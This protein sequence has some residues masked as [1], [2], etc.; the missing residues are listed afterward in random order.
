MQQIGADQGVVEIENQRQEV[1]T[2]LSGTGLFD[3]NG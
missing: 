3:G 1:R 2:F